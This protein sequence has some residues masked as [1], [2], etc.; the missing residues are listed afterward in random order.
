[1]PADMT[2]KKYRMELSLSEHSTQHTQREGRERG[3]KKGYG[4]THSIL[5]Y[6][7][8]MNVKVCFNPLNQVNKEVFIATYKY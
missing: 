4:Y 8:K 5:Q 2:D 1:M 6:Q 3:F 7:F